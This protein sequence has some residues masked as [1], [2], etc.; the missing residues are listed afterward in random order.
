MA[1]KELVGKICMLMKTEIQPAYGALADRPLEPLRVANTK[2]SLR[3]IGWSPRIELA[4]GLRQNDR[5][6]CSASS[7]MMDSNGSR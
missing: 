5:L 2:E 7:E 1:T 6:V 3:L 4:E